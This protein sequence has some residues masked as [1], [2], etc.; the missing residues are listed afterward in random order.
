MSLATLTAQYKRSI[1]RTWKYIH[2]AHHLIQA[3]STAITVSSE[4]KNADSDQSAQKETSINPRRRIDQFRALRCARSHLRRAIRHRTSSV[5]LGTRHNNRRRSLT[6]RSARCRRSRSHADRR[7]AITA[8]DSR[9]LDDDD[10]AVHGVGGGS[11]R[12][13]GHD[14]A[15]RAM[16]MR[17]S[18][19]R[20]GGN[21][22]L[23]RSRQ[24]AAVR[25]RVGGYALG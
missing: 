23:H 16:H 9:S 18:N 19:E 5:A 4:I 14:I 17:G 8:R 12:L 1:Y 3:P 7:R 10:S 15:I 2:Q 11:R 21:G 24:T 6:R 25:S 20:D 22:R 13:D